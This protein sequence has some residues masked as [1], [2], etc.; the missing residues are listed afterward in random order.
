[1]DP[2][3]ANDEVRRVVG[4]INEVDLVQPCRIA[5]GDVRE[6]LAE[7]HAVARHEGCN[8]VKTNNLG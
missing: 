1:M 3:C 6:V 4:T 5:E 2:I 7:V 8:P